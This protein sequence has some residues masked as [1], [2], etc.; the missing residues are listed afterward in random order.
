VPASV[1]QLITARLDTLE[2]TDKALLQDAAV[3][4][5]V[6][7][8]GALAAVAGAPRDEVERWLARM[9]R[10]E[11]VRRVR[12]SSVAGE[13][14]FAFRHVLVRDVAYNQL[15]RAERAD[16]HARLAGWLESLG[17]DR[18]ADRA[19]LLAHHYQQAL[20]Y[21][22]AAGQDAGD[23][24][25]RAR[26]AFRQAGDRAHA[27]NSFPLAARYYAAAV[28]L[29]PAGGPTDESAAGAQRAS[30]LLRLGEASVYSA[31]G[32][33][34]ELTE[35]RDALLAAGRKA[36]A[37][38]AERMLGRLAWMRGQVAERD[39]H[40]LRALELVGGEPPSRSKVAVLAAVA[41]YLVYCDRYAEAVKVAGQAL[42]EA[43]SLGL[44]DREALA[45][46]VI[47]TAKVLMGDE[48]GL[49]D[50]RAS[51]TAL[52]AQRSVHTAAAAN[53]WASMLA[54]RGDIDGYCAAQAVSRRAVERFGARADDYSL[55]KVT[56]AVEHW[57]TGAWDQAMTVADDFVADP[58]TAPPFLEALCRAVR[59][60]IALAGGDLDAAL[61]DAEA[62]YELSRR[63]MDPQTHGTALAFWARALADAGRVDEA[64]A[65][66][67]ELLALLAGGPLHAEIGT[68]LPLAL[69]AVAGDEAAAR[70]AAT[71][72]RPTRWLEAATA[73]V[74]GDHPLA[75]DLYATIG[76]RP[77]EAAA[78]LA[79]GRALA[80][81]DQAAAQ[82]LLTRAA[83]FY[84]KV[85]AEASRA[86]AERLLG[87]V[88]SRA[89]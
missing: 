47:G 4:G 6:G 67:E 59:G 1:G 22:R 75:A 58:G 69:L 13:T 5:E 46:Q 16:R 78:C 62:G 64:A 42:E 51:V 84:T 19:E 73:F 86:E 56:K 18:G 37:A 53:N 41:S 40:H 88:A 79:G 23:L 43:A 89:G 30:L 14:E 12:P 80:T 9:E 26:V 28:E 61:A 65:P 3:L 7:W 63:V 15:P 49:P 77:D 17:A 39:A 70:L 57:W 68:D 38:D 74:A 20:S 11:L 50:L 87:L 76:S 33:E 24:A 71:G 54:T 60:R 25:E 55:I 48:G 34:A 2:L 10:R 82:A 31:G 44:R 8:V 27:L 36:E 21:R 81:G 72:A 85:G 83:A 32:G 35:A 66:L 29:W 45:M 52:E